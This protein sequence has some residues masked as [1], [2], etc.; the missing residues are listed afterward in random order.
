MF[1]RGVI[2]HDQVQLQTLGCF[3]VD[4]FQEGQ[5]LLMSVLSFNAADQP[6]LQIIHRR[7]QRKRAVTNIVMGLCTD[8]TDTQLQSGLRALQALEPCS[9]H[10]NRA[11]GL[12]RAAPDTAR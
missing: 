5:P 9:S 10:R 4:L 7:K 6:T 1:V 8:M 2:I 11:P 3:P 12:Y